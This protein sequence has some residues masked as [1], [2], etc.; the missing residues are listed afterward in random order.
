[1]LYIIDVK[2][3]WIQ[4]ENLLTPVPTA[5]HHHTAIGLHPLL[6]TL[7]SPS[8][9]HTSINLA[10]PLYLRYKI[11]TNSSITQIHLAF[12][13]YTMAKGVL[14]T[15]KVVVVLNGRYAG[16]KALVLKTYE[17]GNGSRRF[18]HAVVAGLA[19]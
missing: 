6:S 17:G 13:I 11:L 9:H 15:G 19:R 18:A 7:P 12:Y 16:R 1:M 5:Y 14:K 10:L 4:S 8:M 3:N 2:P